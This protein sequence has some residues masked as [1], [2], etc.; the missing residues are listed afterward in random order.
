MSYDRDPHR[1]GGGRFVAR[2]PVVWSARHRLGDA[3]HL[4]DLE[5]SLTSPGPPPTSSSIGCCS[6]QWVRVFRVRRFDRR[7][8]PPTEWRTERRLDGRQPSD[9]SPRRPWI[10]QKSFH[11]P[12]N[13]IASLSAPARGRISNAR[14]RRRRVNTPDTPP[15]LIA[16][17]REGTERPPHADAFV[18][19]SPISARTVTSNSN[20]VYGTNGLLRLTDAMELHDAVFDED[21]N[22]VVHGRVAP[23][24]SVGQFGKGLHIR[25]GVVGSDTCARRAFMPAR[26]VPRHPRTSMPLIVEPR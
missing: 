13:L 16:S 25:V 15:S 1:R 24:E 23:T 20:V 7:C 6:W 19:L 10:S 3:A 9:C 18:S 14:Q 21:S 17:V 22:V 2:F 11:E 8:W 12:G 26:M 5:S 4:V